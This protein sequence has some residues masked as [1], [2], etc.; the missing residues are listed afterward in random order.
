VQLQAQ[1]SRQDKPPRHLF[2]LALRRHR[3]RQ[4][5]ENLFFEAQLKKLFLVGLADDFEL[6]K[7]AAA[8]GFQDPLRVVFDQS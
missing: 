1:I 2:F 4:G 6:V 8:K 5:V 7:L 3:L